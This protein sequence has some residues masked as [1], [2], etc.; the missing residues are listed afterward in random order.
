MTGRVAQTKAMNDA[1]MAKKSSFIAVTGRRR[2]GKTYLIREVFEKKFCFSVK[3]I[4]HANTKI[5]LFI[6]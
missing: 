6:K 2:I 4:Q 1:V 5:T 3:G